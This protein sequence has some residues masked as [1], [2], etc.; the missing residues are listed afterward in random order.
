MRLQK[1]FASQSAGAPGGAGGGRS[2]GQP[3]QLGCSLLRCLRGSQPR[4]LCHTERERQIVFALR[5]RSAI[6]SSFIS[7]DAVVIVVIAPRSPLSSHWYHRE[8]YPMAA[9]TNPARHTRARSRCCVCLTPISSA[10][11]HPHTFV[12]MPAFETGPTGKVDRRSLPSLASLAHPPVLRSEATVPARTCGTNFFKETRPSEHE[13]ALGDLIDKIAGREELLTDIYR[14]VLASSTYSPAQNFFAAG[15]D[16]LSAFRVVKVG[17]C[18]SYLAVLCHFLCWSGRC[19]C[20][21]RTAGSEGSAG[22]GHAR[23]GKGVEGAICSQIRGVRA[24]TI[25]L[26][27]RAPSLEYDQRCRRRSQHCSWRIHLL[28]FFFHTS[29]R[30]LLMR[31]AWRMLVGMT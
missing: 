12:L 2:G 14:A 9:T 4:C 7:L 1:R 20:I 16:S 6:C 11:A 28:L 8:R 21:M 26:L 24:W 22:L 13:V 19:S 23:T 3:E 17:W 29:P 10:Y 25:Q 18:W 27:Q 30:L 15:G 31:R 5:D